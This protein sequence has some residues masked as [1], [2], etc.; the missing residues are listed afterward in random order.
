VLERTNIKLA[1]VIS[2]ILGVSGQA[3]LE[4]LIAG[5]AAPATIASLAQRRI[6][7]KMPL[8]DKP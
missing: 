1:P 4:A 7:Q 6:R 5:R 3:M 8:L 2:D